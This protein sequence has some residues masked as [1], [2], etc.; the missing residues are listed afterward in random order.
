MLRMGALSVVRSAQR[1]TVPA[2]THR[3]NS[4]STTPRN[5]FERLLANP[6]GFDK[7]FRGHK[8]NNEAGESAGEAASEAGAKKAGGGPKNEKKPSGNGWGTGGGGKGKKPNWMD[9]LPNSGIGAG[10]GIALTLYM[11]SGESNG[12]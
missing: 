5:W 3:I 4:V 10:I 9:N 11:M 7:F 12:R 2:I 8:K 1:R 6:K